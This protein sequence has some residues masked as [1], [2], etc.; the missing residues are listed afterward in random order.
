MFQQHQLPLEEELQSRVLGSLQEINIHNQAVQIVQ[1]IVELTY[2]AN[3]P[4]EYGTTL[5][6]Q[7]GQLDALRL[8][9]NQSEE[10]KNNLAQLA[11]TGSINPPEDT[12]I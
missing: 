8:L 6:Y 10:A 1:A 4:A 12:P 11:I 5:A 7:Q 2:D 3:K 9:L